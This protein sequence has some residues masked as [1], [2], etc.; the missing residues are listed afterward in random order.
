MTEKELIRETAASK[1]VSDRVTRIWKREVCG[2][3]NHMQFSWIKYYG[4][5][6]IQKFTNL[7][8]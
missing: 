2:C 8:Y 7:Y 4:P 1:K 5:F 6:V 3:Q